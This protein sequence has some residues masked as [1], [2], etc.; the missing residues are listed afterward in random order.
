MI[1]Q[2]ALG[3]FAVPPDDKAFREA[4]VAISNKYESK[5]AEEDAAG[6][7]VIAQ[8]QPAT[9][10]AP[11]SPAPNAAG[12]GGPRVNVSSNLSASALTS[13]SSTASASGRSQSKPLPAAK[14]QESNTGPTSVMPDV[15]GR[16]L[17]AVVQACTQLNLKVS[18]T[19]S[20]VAVRQMPSPGARVRAGDQCRVEFQ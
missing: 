20:G 3:D 11:V 4:L 19:G 1:A 15:R 13:S 17:R 5:A 6:T 14:S 2:V 10:S 7:D 12:T 8:A 18:F 9:E 16:G